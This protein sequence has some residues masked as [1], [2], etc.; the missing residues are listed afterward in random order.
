ML[1]YF[2]EYKNYTEEQKLL[3][4]YLSLK[5][6]F[7]TLEKIETPSKDMSNMDF[8][9]AA[10]LW[11]NSVAEFR[12]D[13]ECKGIIFPLITIVKHLEQSGTPK[14][15]IEAIKNLPPLIKG[16]EFFFYL[17]YLH[18]WNQRASDFIEKMS[19]FSSLFNSIFKEENLHKALD[20]VSLGEK[21]VES[22]LP[23]SA[24]ATTKQVIRSIITL[25]LNR[26]TDINNPFYDFDHFMS[27]LM[28]SMAF[29]FL[30]KEFGI[31]TS[32]LPMSIC[33]PTVSWLTN[34]GSDSLVLSGESLSLLPFFH[35][36]S[37]FDTGCEFIGNPSIIKEQIVFDL[38]D[39]CAS[40]CQRLLHINLTKNEPK[41]LQDTTNYVYIGTLDSFLKETSLTSFKRA[42]LLMSET[43]FSN[44]GKKNNLENGKE[45]F[46]GFD[47]IN[48]IL[49]FFTFKGTEPSYLIYFDKPSR[50]IEFLDLTKETE[51][52]V[53]E[54]NCF[55]DY[56]IAEQAVIDR[57]IK[58]NLS[59]THFFD[60]EDFIEQITSSSE[61]SFSMEMFINTYA[62]HFK[63]RAG[64]KSWFNAYWGKLEQFADVIRGQA[65]EHKQNSKDSG[66][67]SAYE[68]NP[69]D[70]SDCGVIE[71]PKKLHLH[72]D[73]E[74]LQRYKLQKGDIVLGVKGMIGRI[75]FIDTDVSN[76]YVG[77]ATAIIRV[78]DI[79]TINPEYL[80]TYLYGALVEPSIWLTWISNSNSKSINMSK[81]RKLPI[82]RPEYDAEVYVEDTR[83]LFNAWRDYRQVQKLYQIKS[84][85]NLQQMA[86]LN[87]F[88][89]DLSKSADETKKS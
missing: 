87:S 57:F 75:G 86:E 73:L 82:E 53:D 16:Q 64:L 31:D 12:T 30:I 70:I 67:T 23:T 78:K 55:I 37:S 9:Q 36:T 4:V 44:L 41:C 68:L 62:I 54:R 83:K 10:K 25:F 43:E 50:A 34:N 65:I 48:K 61:T 11:G 33:C 28:A 13:S 77:Q 45:L 29:P 3:L 26:P 60:K 51:I 14:E 38:R 69:G 80:F 71:I 27:K 15:I 74:P 42:C 7:L 63:K 84:L 47:K 40:I 6:T 19:D 81:L 72:A 2:E 46:L 39:T 66:I 8:E 20:V 76:W 22:L 32:I 18:E 79:E 56:S 58:K 17:D 85:P 24:D 49:K 1:N 89:T 52:I 21:S 35:A 5:L 59:C 88:L